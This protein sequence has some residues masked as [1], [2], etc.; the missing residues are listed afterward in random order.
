VNIFALKINNK[1][2]DSVLTDLLGLIDKKKRDRL[3]KFVFWQDL[4]R[5]LLADLLVRKVIIETYCISNE[6]IEFGVNEFGKPYYKTLKDF[7]F[8]VSHSGDWIVCAIDNKPIGIDIE[9]ISACINLGISE[10]FFS[11]KEHDDLLSKIDPFDYFF[12]LWSLKE[13]YIK[14]IGKGLSHPLNTFSMKLNNSKIY[15]E[16]HNKILQDIYFKQYNIDK[17]YKMAICSLNPNMSNK[18]SILSINDVVNTF[19]ASRIET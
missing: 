13:S 15:I 12:T 6:E 8:N 2:D 3:L 11:N 1:L 9:K 16:S 5:S 7:H 19:I 4:H 17:E 14:Y 18:V 10:N